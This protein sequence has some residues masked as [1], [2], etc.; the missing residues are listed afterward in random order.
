MKGPTLALCIPAYN[1]ARHLPRL[2][3]SAANQTI[4]FDEIW[5]YDDCSADDTAEVARQFGAIV[6]RGDKNRGCSFG[7]NRLAE[8]TECDWLHFQDADDEL[9]PSYVENAHKW[10]NTQDAPDVILFSYE[11]RQNDTNEL[12]SI[13]AYDNQR[14]RNDPIRYSIL[15]QINCISGLYCR[16][17]FLAAGGFDLDPNVLYNEDVAMHCQLARAGLRFAADS[18]VV[19]MNYRLGGSMSQANQIKCA[20]AHYYVLKKA[21]EK[22]DGKYAEEIA[23]KLWL[24]AGVS[25]SYLD[26]DTADAAVRLAVQLRG[27][28]PSEAD[29]RLQGLCAIN[30]R[31]ALRI[32]EFWIRLAKPRLRANHPR[33]SPASL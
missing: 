31:V 18:T 27:R 23:H 20:R 30:P 22:L 14:L 19:A 25:A 7:R 29:W 12:I 6:V 5:V 15:E 8:S 11:Y 9:Y 1:A 26:W 10:M 32:R 24:L 16:R 4:L 17:S 2:L 13:R 33:F 3:E 28:M 21:A